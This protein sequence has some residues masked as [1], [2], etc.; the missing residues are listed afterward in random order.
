[1]A[2]KLNKNRKMDPG[3][4]KMAGE[5]NEVRQ[6]NYLYEGHSK[7]KELDKDMIIDCSLIKNVQKSLVVVSYA[8][9]SEV[10]VTTKGANLGSTLYSN[11][12][13]Y[14]VDGVVQGD[15][16]RKVLKYFATGNGS[17]NSCESVF[18]D[19]VNKKVSVDRFNRVN[20]LYRVSAHEIKEF[21]VR[22]KNLNLATC[23]VDTFRTIGLD[24]DVICRA[25]QELSIDVAKDASK[26]IG[27]NIHS[28]INCKTNAYSDVISKKD[29]INNM[30]DGI[31]MMLKTD[32]L[33]SFKYEMKVSEDFA[34]LEDVAA[35]NQTAVANA[36]VKDSIGIAQEAINTGMTRAMEDVVKTL[37]NSDGSKY[38]AY[39]N[40]VEIAKNPITEEDAIIA[41]MVKMAIYAF[42]AISGMWNA[43]YENE[44]YSNAYVQ[45]FAGHVRSALYTEGAKLGVKPEDVV[46]Y[47][48]AASFAYVDKDDNINDSSYGK[49]YAVK[50]IFPRE[51]ILEYIDGT[52]PRNA[53]ET[54]L[55]LKHSNVDLYVDD[56]LSFVD[57]VYTNEDGVFVMLEENYTGDAVITE[58][59][60]I[61]AIYDF[62]SY[63]EVG[64]AVMSK[65]CVKNAF[66]QNE[67]VNS[68]ECVDGFDKELPNF[69]PEMSAAVMQSLGYAGISG[70]YVAV[71]NKDKSVTIVG[72]MFT[73]H[74]TEGNARIPSGI[75]TKKGGFV[76]FTK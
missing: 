3:F 41:H 68:M 8:A 43:K 26:D 66:A 62:Y 1:M 25:L 20:I 11:P 51:F 33:G 64:Y 45:E 27:I 72:E 7:A 14:F 2:L 76:C 23:T 71:L 74:K 15:K 58:E 18:V 53:L 73:I 47:A 34:F 57:G 30:K 65:T 36:I 48:I 6:A 49:L 17:I 69:N 55:T 52:D 32:K 4:M 22:V 50:S 28:L 19:G 12:E 63:K 75:I 40:Y 24:L 42:N 5:I 46:K 37:K 29:V 61:V 9:G 60:E 35:D 70:K 10:G 39:K 56:K 54:C 38:D 13:Q 21:M 67:F 44:A 16:V 59:G 31:D